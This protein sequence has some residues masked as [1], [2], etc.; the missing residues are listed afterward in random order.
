MLTTTNAHTPVFL[1]EAVAALNVR[2]EGVYLDGTLGR[3][4]HSQKILEQLNDDGRLVALDRDMAAIEVGKEVFSGDERVLLMHGDFAH[5]ED[6]LE[7]Q[8]GENKPTGFDGILLDLGVSSPQ[9]DQAERGFSFMREGDLDMRMD[10]THGQ[11]AAQWLASAE[12]VEIANVIYQLGEEKFSRCI[13]RA[14][15][16]Q[17]IEEP[18]TTTSQ[19]VAL[20]EEAIPRKEKNKHPATRTFQAIRMHINDELGQLKSVLPQAVRL[21]NDG[22]RLSVISFHSLEDRVVKRFFRELSKGKS[23]PKHIPIVEEYQAPL[24]TVGKALKPSAEEIQR[25]PRSR[26]AVLR[27]AQRT[28]VAYE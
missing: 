12:E 10:N 8:S 27:V 7:R 9:L 11:T 2:P 6:V 24:T 26:S 23:L 17:R 18:I 16:A 15:V 13:A 5:L 28:G 25:N 21:L 1:Q 19:L 4:G 3:A 22:G 14:I 20:L